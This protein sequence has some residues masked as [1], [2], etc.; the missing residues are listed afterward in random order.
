ML[1]KNDTVGYLLSFALYGS[2][3]Q[4]FFNLCGMANCYCRKTSCVPVIG[5]AA[6][7]GCTP[8]NFTFPFSDQGNVVGTLLLNSSSYEMNYV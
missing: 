4:K 6:C 5:S 2:L 3:A 7:L 8:E 1:D